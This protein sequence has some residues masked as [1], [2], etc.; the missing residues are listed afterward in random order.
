MPEKETNRWCCRI[1]PIV[2]I[3]ISLV[4]AAAAWYFDEEVHR[5]TFLKSRGEFIQF[6][7]TTLFIAF[8]P[9]GLFYYLNDKEKV[10]QKAK[11]FALLGFIP[12]LVYLV[13]IIL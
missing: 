11:P 4:I 1:Y 3:L 10:Q 5:F 9:I 6:I 8:L 12:A 7:G 13:F 2:L